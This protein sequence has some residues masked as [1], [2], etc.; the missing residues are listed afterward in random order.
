MNIARLGA[1]LDT[2]CAV[3]HRLFEDGGHL[4]L[5]RHQ[6]KSVWGTLQLDV[7]WCIL[8]HCRLKL[9]RIF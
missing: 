9:F 2:R 1:N 8:L 3:C 4:F 7:V 6:V 5:R